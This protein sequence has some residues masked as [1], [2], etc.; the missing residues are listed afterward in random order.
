MFSIGGFQFLTHGGLIM[1]IHTS[2]D[3][4]AN[5]L[6]MRNQ[7]ESCGKWGIPLVKKDRINLNEVRL[8]AC[9]DT[10]TKDSEKKSNAVSISL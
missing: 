9:S 5:P 1:V 2:R 8:I 6:F 3:M 7:F 4:R 10:R